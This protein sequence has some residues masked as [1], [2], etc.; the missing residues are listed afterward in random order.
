MCTVVL[1]P[2]KVNVLTELMI[3]Q[4]I[5]GSKKSLDLKLGFMVCIIPQSS[6]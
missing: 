5:S 2:A 1:L 3:H 6:D 4:N